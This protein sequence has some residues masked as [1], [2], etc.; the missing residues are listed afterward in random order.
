MTEEQARALVGTLTTDEK[1]MLLDVLEKLE[2]AR[3][4]KAAPV[5]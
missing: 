5:L 3:Q 1:L 4:K 2:Q